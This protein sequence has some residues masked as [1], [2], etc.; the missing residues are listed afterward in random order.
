VHRAAP[1]R[2][3]PVTFTLDR[4]DSAHLALERNFEQMVL[5]AKM[6]LDRDL[7]MPAI[8]LVYSL[9]DAFAWATAPKNKDTRGRFESWLAKYVYPEDALPCTPTELY[10]ARCAALHTLTSKSDLH[11]RGKL[12]E[13][14]YAWGPAKEDVAS[15]VAAF[16][17]LKDRFVAL[18]IG[19]LLEA[20]ARGIHRTL[21]AA[22]SDPEL[23]KNLGK[24]ASMH[25]DQLPIALVEAAAAGLRERNGDANGN[26]V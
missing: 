19:E 4:M 16:A 1:C 23:S 21:Q 6:C 2:N 25:F 7:P 12:R 5:G 26:A 9:I 8:V 3:V 22:E 10:A 14:A 17:N 13:I 11:V 20:V 15:D 18:H 24:T